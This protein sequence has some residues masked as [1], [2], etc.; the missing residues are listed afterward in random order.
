MFHYTSSLLTA[1][2][3]SESSSTNCAAGVAARPAESAP[4][5]CL[6]VEVLMAVPYKRW[7][8]IL[9]PVTAPPFASVDAGSLLAPSGFYA[10]A[11]KRV[12]RQPSLSQVAMCLA[13]WCVL[14]WQ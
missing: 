13:A 2:S 9:S 5:H 14:Q 1:G 8:G 6:N 3:G 4:D 7:L 10:N 12:V 11:Q